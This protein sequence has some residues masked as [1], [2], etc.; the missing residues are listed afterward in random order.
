MSQPADANVPLP[1][2]EQFEALHWARVRSPTSTWRGDRWIAEE[3]ERLGWLEGVLRVGG[4]ELNHLDYVYIL[5]DLGREAY[6]SY[7]AAQ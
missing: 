3:C 6:L 2:K 5:T 1:T 7:R 4:D